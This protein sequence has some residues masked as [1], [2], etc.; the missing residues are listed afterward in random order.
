[1][2]GQAWVDSLDDEDV[3]ICAGCANYFILQDLE[4]VCNGEWACKPCWYNIMEGIVA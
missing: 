3:C 2:M 4:P 1:M